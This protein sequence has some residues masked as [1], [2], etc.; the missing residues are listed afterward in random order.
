MTKT[1]SFFRGM[2]E[3]IMMLRL[4]E[5]SMSKTVQQ[6]YPVV[7]LRGII[8]TIIIASFCVINFLCISHLLGRPRFCFNLNYNNPQSRH[9]QSDIVK[10]VPVPVDEA[11]AVSGIV[12]AFPNLTKR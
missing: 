7:V 3:D 1:D 12:D 9:T 2:H 5:P 8:E 4:R 11:D 6:L 10:V